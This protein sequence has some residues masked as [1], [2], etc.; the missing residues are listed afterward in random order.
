MIQGVEEDLEI[1]KRRVADA[2][3][4]PSCATNGSGSR[5]GWRDAHSLRR[6]AS[7]KKVNDHD[8]LSGAEGW[9]RA[10]D[11]VFDTAW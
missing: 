1:T 9:R 4:Q 2:K 7:E 11:R 5:Y 3:A 6:E 10:S 8:E